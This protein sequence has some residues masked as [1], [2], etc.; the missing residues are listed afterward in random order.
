MCPW[1][2]LLCCGVHGS[3]AYCTCLPLACAAHGLKIL[4]RHHVLAQPSPNVASV[5]HPPACLSPA[6]PARALPI[7]RTW[8]GPWSGSALP[9]HST[10]ISGPT[11]AHALAVQIDGAV[12]RG[13]LSRFQLRNL[14]AVYHINGGCW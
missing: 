7:C 9:L 8:I 5:G 3:Q 1:L 4:H 11:S 2:L 6:L 13:L 14:H 10:I 12:E